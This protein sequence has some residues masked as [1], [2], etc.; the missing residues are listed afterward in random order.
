MFSVEYDSG[1]VSET[2]DARLFQSLTAAVPGEITVIGDRTL[3]S[4]DTDIN[5]Y[6]GFNVKYYYRTDSGDDTLILCRPI[7]TE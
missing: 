2:K 7:K 1:I 5:D 3:N 6:L 4:G